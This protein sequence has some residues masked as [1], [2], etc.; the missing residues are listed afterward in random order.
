MGPATACGPH[1]KKLVW[2]VRLLLNCHLI[3]IFIHI[4][5]CLQ[6]AQ[7]IQI[8]LMTKAKLIKAYSERR[9][10]ILVWL[11]ELLHSEEYFSYTE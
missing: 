11:S 7:L 2:P 3:W 5:K 10:V 6:I 1:G 4:Y 8:Q 9:S